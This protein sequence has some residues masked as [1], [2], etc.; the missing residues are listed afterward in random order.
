[1]DS[2]NNLEKRTITLIHNLI[3]TG[4]LVADKLGYNKKLGIGKNAIVLPP[5]LRP[6]QILLN[7]FA[8]Y[9]P[10]EADKIRADV[11][12]SFA[13]IQT[14]KNRFEE[15]YLR[16]DSAMRRADSNGADKMRAGYIKVQRALRN[17]FPELEIRLK[18][19]A[20]QGIVYFP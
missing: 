8:L 15:E 20:P 9:V 14:V 2:G 6:C 10:K 18:D 7:I 17:S 5:E 1:M 3:Y 11:K 19:S 16:Q 13:D 12:I 4:N